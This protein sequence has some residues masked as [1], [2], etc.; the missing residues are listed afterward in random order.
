MNGSFHFI[1]YLIISH[2]IAK[3]CGFLNH[4]LN[5]FWNCFSIDTDTNVLK[6][7]RVSIFG[8]TY[9][10]IVLLF[11]NFKQVI[12]LGFESGYSIDCRFQHTINPAEKLYEFY[13]IIDVI[14]RHLAIEVI[15]SISNYF[16]FSNCSLNSSLFHPKVNCHSINHNFI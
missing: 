14:N 5:L 6:L 10:T 7:I 15:T 9:Y 16:A 12:C 3:T 4:F 2:W 11:Q 13:F 8:I 1:L